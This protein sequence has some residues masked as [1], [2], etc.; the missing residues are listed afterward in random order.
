MLFFVKDPVRDDGCFNVRPDTYLFDTY[1]LRLSEPS[2]TGHKPSQLKNDAKSSAK[3]R[4]GKQ[5]EKTDNVQGAM[6]AAFAK[7]KA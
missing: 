6:A 3:T 1:L 7:L 5:R 2:Q 4:P